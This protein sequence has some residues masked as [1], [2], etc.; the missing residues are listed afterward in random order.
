MA[1]ATPLPLTAQMANGR[2]VTVA[3]TIGMT[4]IPETRYAADD[5]S[6]SRIAL[7]APDSVHFVIVFERVILETNEREFSLLMFRT[8]QVF[9]RPIPKRLVSMRSRSNR[10]GIRNVKWLDNGNLVFLGE[11]QGT[12]H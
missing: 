3:D 7:F 8:D 4:T 11:A 1:L 12:S 10:D 5:V 2:T 6:K 9:S